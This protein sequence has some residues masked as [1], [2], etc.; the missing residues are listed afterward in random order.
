MDEA[1]DNNGRMTAVEREAVNDPNSLN[2]L[3]NP[4]Q[5][6]AV[7]EK[8]LR[9]GYITTY[10][11]E[12][13]GKHKTEFVSDGKPLLNDQG[14]QSVMSM[15]MSVI[16]KNVVFGNLTSEEI[17]NI[18]TNFHQSLA[19]MLIRGYDAFGIKEINDYHTIIKIVTNFARIFLSRTKDGIDRE[20]LTQSHRS[21][22]T[23][24]NGDGKKKSFFG[25]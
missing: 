2:I 6:L 17:S 16:N 5:E 14:V 10:Y 19:S 3:I 9:G 20:L 22:E 13:L 21:V 15:A 25:L 7:I 11:D 1:Q 8:S 24:Q 12:D 18:M 4:S 23:I